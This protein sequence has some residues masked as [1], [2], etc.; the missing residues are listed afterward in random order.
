MTTSFCEDFCK[1][2]TVIKQMLGLFLR[3]LNTEKLR[4]KFKF[5]EKGKI[6]NTRFSFQPYLFRLHL[7]SCLK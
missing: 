2:K 7:A 1:H 3:H 6:K 4:R 5:R